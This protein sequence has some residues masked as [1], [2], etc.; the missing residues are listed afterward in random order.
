MGGVEKWNTFRNECTIGF[1]FD[2]LQRKWFPTGLPH[3]PGG[4]WISSPSVAF[5]WRWRAPCHRTPRPGLFA[6]KQ[7]NNLLT[8]Q[9]LIIN[10]FF[11]FWCKQTNSRTWSRFLYVLAMFFFRVWMVPTTQ[12]KHPN[13]VKDSRATASWASSAQACSRK[14]LGLFLRQAEWNHGQC[15]LLSGRFWTNTG[16]VK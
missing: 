15:F 16:K 11:K 1:L 13:P 9:I 14:S 4:V 8:T 5:C 7:L 10:K 2:P 6:K 3:W 12:Q